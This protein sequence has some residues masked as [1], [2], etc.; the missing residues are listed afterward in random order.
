MKRLVRALAGLLTVTCMA[1]SGF[2]QTPGKPVRIVLGFPAGGGSD[3]VLRVIAQR[4]AQQLGQPV[5]ID[6]KPGAD[7]IIAADAVAK[8][9]PDGTTLYFASSNALVAAP[10]LRGHQGVPYDPFKDFT[11]VAKL[12]RFALVMATAPNLPAKTYSEFIQYVRS[13]PGALNYASGHSVGRLAAIQ[14]LN[15]AKLDMLHVPY[16]GDAPAL[17]D[18]ITGRVHMIFSTEAA[19]RGFVK[20]GKL[21]ALLA[22][23]DTRSAQLPGVPTAR[24]VGLRISVSPWAGLYGPANMPAAA[25]EHINKALH[26]ALS[27]N[28]ARELLDKYG[29]EPSVSS[30]AEMA[31]IHREEYDVFHKAVHEDGIKFE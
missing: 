18:L 20:D 6:N 14:F 9:A 11:P 26:A 17:T 27:G 23:R 10:V 22:L 30:P 29:F 8:A 28:E 2:A 15:L 1:A 25:V 31:A 5:V 7:G 12:G 19:V 4:L 16:K 13:K 3:T 21:N 24:E